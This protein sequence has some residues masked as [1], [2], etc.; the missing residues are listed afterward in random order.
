MRACAGVD[1]SA[2]HRVGRPRAAQ[3][4]ITEQDVTN[5]VV[6]SLSGTSQVSPTYWLDPHNGVSYPIVAQTP[7]TG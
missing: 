3:L 1:L 2:V 6:A 7:S 5:A 4:G